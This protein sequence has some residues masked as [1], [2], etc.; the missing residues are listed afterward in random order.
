MVTMLGY[1]GLKCHVP[2]LKKC[3]ILFL[4]FVG[5]PQP[6]LAA[7][8][9]RDWQFLPAGGQCVQTVSPAGY[10]SHQVRYSVLVILESRP[11][12]NEDTLIFSSSFANIKCY[13]AIILRGNGEKFTGVI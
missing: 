5:D 3:T 12:F 11:M 13:K 4:H 9:G 2:Y 6:A 7:S 10:W 1:L 8:D